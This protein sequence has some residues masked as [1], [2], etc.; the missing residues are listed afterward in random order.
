[1]PSTLCQSVNTPSLSAPR[2]PYDHLNSPVAQVN[3]PMCRQRSVEL[4]EH[5]DAIESEACEF[6]F[7]SDSGDSSDDDDFEGYVPQ[8]LAYGH[9]APDTSSYDHGSNGHGGNGETSDAD[10]VA[11]TGSCVDIDAF[12]SQGAAAT[13]D[14][15]AVPYSPRVEAP[16]SPVSEIIDLYSDDAADAQSFSSRDTNGK[17]TLRRTGHV[18]PRGRRTPPSS[19]DDRVAKL[20]LLVRK[21]GEALEEVREQLRRSEGRRERMQARVEV[22]IEESHERLM[23]FARDVQI[24][25]L[26]RHT[27]ANLRMDNWER[28]VADVDR[29]SKDTQSRLLA[30]LANQAAEEG[31]LRRLLQ[32]L[33]ASLPPLDHG[34]SSR[35]KVAERPRTPF[36]SPFAFDVKQ[37]DRVETELAPLLARVLGHMGGASEQLG[38]QVAKLEADLDLLRGTDGNN[39]DRVTGVGAFR[40]GGRPEGDRGSSSS[41]VRPASTV[42]GGSRLEQSIT[43][44][45]YIRTR[46]TE[47]F[48]STSASVLSAPRPD[49]GEWEA[50]APARGIARQQRVKK[51]GRSSRLQASS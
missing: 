23:D 27:L 26:R 32:G 42:S 49:R 11:F 36:P 29:V 19:S 8:A 24:D 37:G 1:M 46:H 18:K 13:A 33:E 7:A 6:D 44:E 38:L 20:E 4:I 21:Q 5:A 50:P 40:L 2:S 34:K 30:V 51:G 12:V 10:S 45:D 17:C 28:Y 9:P 25:D 35:Q 16:Y 31:K 47:V 15:A 22:G 43:T 48:S 41:S 14:S 3:S 39:G